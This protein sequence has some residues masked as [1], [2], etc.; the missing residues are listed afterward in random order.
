[1]RHFLLQDLLHLFGA[2]TDK[3]VA[4]P[5]SVKLLKQLGAAKTAKFFF[6]LLRECLCLFRNRTF[7]H[8]AKRH[9]CAGYRSA[10]L[11]AAD[12]A[13]ETLRPVSKGSFVYSSSEQSTLCAQLQPSP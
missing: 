9:D 13:A 2:I 3:G 12:A 6:E 7:F 1:M 10:D 8:K 11:T 4:V 5:F